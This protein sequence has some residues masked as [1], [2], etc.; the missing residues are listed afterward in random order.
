MIFIG[1]FINKYQVLFTDFIYLD[2]QDNYYDMMR[3]ELS[4]QIE[5]CFKK[6]T[7]KATCEMVFDDEELNNDIDEFILTNYVVDKY[8]RKFDMESVFSKKIIA[9]NHMIYEYICNDVFGTLI[10][11]GINNAEELVN[12]IKK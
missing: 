7:D 10:T 6:H 11:M 8:I 1:I 3:Y 9:H 5:V 12:H 2:N 4:K